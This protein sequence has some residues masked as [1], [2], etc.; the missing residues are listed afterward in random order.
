MGTIDSIDKVQVK[1]EGELFS[2]L[3]PLIVYFCSSFAIH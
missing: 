2:T 3:L 1:L